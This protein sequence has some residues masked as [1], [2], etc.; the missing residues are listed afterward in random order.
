MSRFIQFNLNG[1]G[2]SGPVYVNVDDIAA[3][4]G[5]FS[6]DGIGAIILKSGVRFC[7]LEDVDEIRDNVKGEGDL[8]SFNV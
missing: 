4:T 5:D 3:F 7:V 1:P 6:E 8:N 2:E